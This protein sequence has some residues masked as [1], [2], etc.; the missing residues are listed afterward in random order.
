MLSPDIANS[1]L[2]VVLGTD[3]II[4]PSRRINLQC[5][6]IGVH[7]KPLLPTTHPVRQVELYAKA[8]KAPQE[9][10]GSEGYGL[11]KERKTGASFRR[12]NGRRLF[13]R[14]FVVL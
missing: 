6:V 2:F 3:Y 8:W 10:G 11:D 14:P 1:T 9:T 7:R 13:R 12:N 4:Q 5:S